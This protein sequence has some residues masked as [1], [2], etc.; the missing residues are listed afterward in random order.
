[1]RHASLHRL[2]VLALFSATVSLAAG[3][4]AGE[5][6][7]DWGIPF[8]GT[9][10]PLNAITDVPGVTVGQV[11]L[12]SGSGPLIKGKGPVRT[13]VT[14]ILPRGKTFDPVFAGSFSFNGNGDMTGTHWVAESG[15]LETPILLTSTGSVGVVRDATWQWI[16]KNGLYESFA[17]EYWYA[18]PLVS[19]TYDGFLND[20]SGQH[21]K[22]E[23][24]FQALDTA[25]SGPV[26]EGSVG[27]GTG[28]MAHWFK[29]GTGTSSRL[30]EGR[31]GK[32]TVGVLV[33]A[34]YGGRHEMRIAGLPIS[35]ALKDVE[36]LVPNAIPSSTRPLAQSSGIP[37][38]SETGSI[39]V[40][41]ATDA[42]L[43][44]LQCQRLARRATVG[45]SRVGGKGGNGS[46]DLFFAFATGNP[47]A[48]SNVKVTALKRYPNGAMDPLFTAVADATEEAI[49]NAMVAARDMTGI[50]GNAVRALPKKEVQ[51]FLREHRLLK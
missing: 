12:I 10:G 5:R 41:I 14:A 4:H 49:L 46:G 40:I 42:P 13:G 43:D 30:V 2:S 29:G 15:F 34:N 6:A 33:Q 37:A 7:R 38:D 24:A 1:M 19:E 3:V 9:P 16:E 31:L 23:H 17:K 51:E 45:L 35:K 39:V 27:G 11:T 32:Y 36:S 26:D 20:I 18:Y 44:A 25:G 28:M 22:A 48:F 47:G 50:Q 21:V 8:H